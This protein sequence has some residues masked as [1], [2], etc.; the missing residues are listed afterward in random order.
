ML[1][2]ANAAFRAINMALAQADVRIQ[3]AKAASPA[4]TAAAG[5]K[6][7]ASVRLLQ[8]ALA[9]EGQGLSDMVQDVCTSVLPSTE[10][11]ERPEQ[12]LPLD[13][14]CPSQPPGW[15]PSP[16]PSFSVMPR[17]V[18]LQSLACQSLK[19]ALLPAL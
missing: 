12:V 1:Q 4:S 6:Q 19:C 3:A 10:T 7:A 18:L 15:P 2:E 11:I 14:L 5:E 16:Q 9:T 17:Q 8:E 13:C